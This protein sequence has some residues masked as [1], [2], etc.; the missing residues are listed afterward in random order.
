[1]LIDEG[2]TTYFYV[3]SL[4]YIKKER[5]QK[6]DTHQSKHYLGAWHPVLRRRRKRQE[7]LSFP[8]GDIGYF[9]FYLSGW[10]ERL[11]RRY[12]PSRLLWRSGDYSGYADS[13]T[14]W[15]GKSYWMALVVDLWWYN[16][17]SLFGKSRRGISDF[18]FAIIRHAHSIYLILTAFSLPEVL[19]I[20][21]TVGE[22]IRDRC[23][24]LTEMND[25][26]YKKRSYR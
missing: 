10:P 14:V 22:W 16:W 12:T 23:N 1:M 26:K 18:S 6:Y 19:T 15:T 20:L 4:S 5:E 2:A 7:R 25:N 13:C 3:G 24:A 17:D 9:F 21:K 11:C 8:V